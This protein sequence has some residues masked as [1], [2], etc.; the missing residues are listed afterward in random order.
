V[1]GGKLIAA[2][3]HAR[4]VRHDD[5][6]ALHTFSAAA[7][8]V[9]TLIVRDSQRL[10]LAVP[11]SAAFRSAAP[12]EPGHMLLTMAIV[13]SRDRCANR[14]AAVVDM[15]GGSLAQQSLLAALFHCAAVAFEPVPRYAA[16]SRR[17]IA[18]ND[19]GAERSADSA[20]I[21]V[22]EALPLASDAPRQ[23]RVNM[24]V[25][26]R[27]CWTCCGVRATNVDTRRFNSSVESAS[28]LAPTVRFASALAPTIKSVLLARV[29]IA[30]WEA[31]S[32]RSLLAESRLRPL[33]I[34]LTVEARGHEWPPDVLEAIDHALRLS[35]VGKQIPDHWFQLAELG[36]PRWQTHA[37]ALF[38]GDS[39][40][41]PLVERASRSVGSAA[42]WGEVSLQFFPFNSS[43]SLVELVQQEPR[44]HVWLTRDSL[45]LDRN[46]AAG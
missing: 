30:G 25:P 15:V 19:A 38:S 24:F 18:L 42:R 45:V 37:N 40:A 4:A 28:L 13:H 26:V 8:T 17:V 29:A 9:F 23:H 12:L 6:E 36:H 34:L 43:D 5:D 39:G 11:R 14:T 46:A 35:Y 7:T 32:M 2:V 20:S 21:S 16:F 1:S 10:V 3:A 44:F 27:D 22:V 41:K 31:E 33:N